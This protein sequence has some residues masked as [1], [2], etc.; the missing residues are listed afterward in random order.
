MDKFK[1]EPNRAN[2]NRFR[3]EK[4]NVLR[5]SRNVTPLELSKFLG[6]NSNTTVRNFELNKHRPPAEIETRL[7]EFFKVEKDYFRKD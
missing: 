7:C 6:Y 1:I 2:V 4:L 5:K 3:G